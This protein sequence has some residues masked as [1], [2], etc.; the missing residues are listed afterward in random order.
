M[1]PTTIDIILVAS[2]LALP[3]LFSLAIIVIFS[4]KKERYDENCED[5]VWWKSYFISNHKRRFKLG[6]YNYLFNY[7][8]NT[9]SYCIYR[10]YDIQSKK[11]VD[12]QIVRIKYD[13]NWLYFYPILFVRAFNVVSKSWFIVLQ[14]KIYSSVI[15]F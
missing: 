2:A 10:D 11:K 1:E 8:S 7:L 13:P 6:N 9:P 3:I 4:A 14:A 15:T 5:K 12:L